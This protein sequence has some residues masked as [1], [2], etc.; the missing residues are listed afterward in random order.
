MY[1]LTSDEFFTNSNKAIAT[2]IRAPQENFPEHSH[3]FQ[4]LFIVSKGSGTHVINDTPNNI[5]KNQVCFV[6]P[7]DRHLFENVDNLYLSNILF[8]KDSIYMPAGL[9]DYIPDDNSDQKS[10]H[11]STTSM[12]KITSLIKILDRELHVET[13]G[14]DLMAQ[15]LF[16]QLIVELH[17]GKL[18]PVETVDMDDKVMQVIEWLKYNYSEEFNI[19]EVSDRFQL[20]T[21]TL[22]RKIK[23]ITNLSFNNYLH[24]IRIN[25]AIQMLQYSDLSIT[26]IAFQVG[27][28]DSN[29][30]STKFKKVTQKSPSAYR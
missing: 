14:S 4:E 22:S 23:Q 19:D 10:W 18:S 29:Y 16:Q 2:E 7:Q 1:Q 3:D 21:R 25:N 6:D 8:R 5:S 28:S 17:R 20:S 15:A 30:F 27:Y 12:E 26:D 11:I 24:Q 13:I 9:K